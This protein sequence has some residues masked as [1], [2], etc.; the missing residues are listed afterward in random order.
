MSRAPSRLG[1]R[2]PESG[3]SFF[4]F[5]FP[6]PFRKRGCHLLVPIPGCGLRHD[7]LPPT[8]SHNG[9]FSPGLI[10]FSEQ[11]LAEFLFFPPFLLPPFSGGSFFPPLLPQLYPIRYAISFYMVDCLSLGFPHRETPPVFLIFLF[12]SHPLPSD[13]RAFCPVPHHR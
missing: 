11:A 8:N 1:R 4:S 13:F 2:P 9:G 5:G 10:Y 6:P 3:L 7:Q 12:P